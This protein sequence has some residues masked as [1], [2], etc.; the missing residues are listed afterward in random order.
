MSNSVGCMSDYR[1]ILG[2]LHLRLIMLTEKILV[3]LTCNK[4]LSLC[5]QFF[6]IINQF[7]KP[8]FFTIRITRWRGNV[9]MFCE[10]P[11]IYIS[12]VLNIKLT[13][14]RNITIS[15]SF[16]DGRN[17]WKLNT[18]Y[19]V[20]FILVACNDWFLGRHKLTFCAFSTA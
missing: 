17:S 4:D 13:K 12:I 15:H 1:R 5:C 10:L 7:D 11:L 2:I 6:N 20:E 9:F 18:F 19:F 8:C 16:Y 3:A 14:R